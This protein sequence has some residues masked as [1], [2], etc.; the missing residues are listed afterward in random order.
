MK[1][2]RPVLAAVVLAVVSVLSCT[3][4]TAPRTPATP[5]S[6]LVGSLLGSLQLL[7]CSPLPYDSASQTIG[8]AGGVLHVGP[9]TLLVPA[10]ALDSAVTITGVAPSGT[11][12]LVRFQPEGLTFDRAA[13]LT[14]S[15]SNCSLVSTLLPK[16]VVYTNDA[17]DIVEA[18]LSLDNI[19]SRKV[20][21]QVRH[22]SG[23][24]VAF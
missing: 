18:L 5:E 2:A 1:R 14:L 10:G 16:R 19:F 21:G 13:S 3:E 15:Y 23:Y 17:M 6:S 8:P 11:V 12:R 20:T 22:F 24:A 9:H 7:S 4:P